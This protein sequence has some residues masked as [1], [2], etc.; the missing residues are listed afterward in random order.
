MLR[1]VLILCLVGAP[2][3]AQVDH[4]ALRDRVLAVLEGQYSAFREATGVLAEVAVRHCDEGAPVA[5]A[6]AALRGAWLAWAALDSYQFGPAELQGAVLSVNFWPDKKNFVGRAVRGLGGLSP[7]DQ[8]NPAVIAE[9]SAAAQ[10]LPAI[11]RLL[12]GDAPACPALV[13]ISAHLADVA[14]A[15]E[16]GW[17]GPDGWAALVRGAGPENPVYLS[18]DEFTKAMFTALDFGLFR[19]AEQRLGR[20]LGTFE[21]SFPKRAEAWRSGL[22][23][24]I[25]AAQVL[26]VFAMLRDG[27]ADAVPDEDLAPVLRRIPVLAEQVMRLEPPIPEAV[28][29]PYLRIR[30]E[31]IQTRVREARTALA[32][33]IGPALGIEPGFSPADGD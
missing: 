10:G 29:D 23:G 1:L 32:D 9:G 21:R 33:R 3:S 16:Q 15:L 27:F 6:Q 14:G 19:V 11:E 28:A 31:A 13:G 26:G 24:E 25:A 20:P 8:R 2:L 22:T 17:F 30:V 4:G 18:P 7:E 12:Y 5:E